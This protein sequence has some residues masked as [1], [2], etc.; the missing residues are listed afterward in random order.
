VFLNSIRFSIRIDLHF[1]VWRY[2]PAIPALGR[3]RKEGYELK[4]SLG[5]IMNLRV[6]WATYEGPVSALSP[7]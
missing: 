5:Y 2:L 6:V 7:Q 3:L 4:A 1:W